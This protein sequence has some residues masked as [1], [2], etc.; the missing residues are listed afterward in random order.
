MRISPISLNVMRNN[1]KAILKRENNSQ[2]TSF[3]AQEPTLIPLGAPQQ[4]T[5]VVKGKNLNNLFNIENNPNLSTQ[6]CGPNTILTPKN[7]ISL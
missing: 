3:G 1:N 7:C 4:G 5:L 6:K 2:K